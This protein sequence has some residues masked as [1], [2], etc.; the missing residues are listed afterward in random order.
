MAR[1]NYRIHNREQGVVLV[2]IGLS[3]NNKQKK[4]NI[5]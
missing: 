1:M 3:N 2:S 4:I 5:S